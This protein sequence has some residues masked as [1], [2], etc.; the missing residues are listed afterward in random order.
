[1]VIN[2]DIPVLGGSRINCFV[3]LNSAVT[4]AAECVANIYFE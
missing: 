2:V 3:D 4:N 1:M